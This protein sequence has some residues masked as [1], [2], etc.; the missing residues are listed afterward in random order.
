MLLRILRRPR[1]PPA[2]RSLAE[3]TRPRDRSGRRCGPGLKP[4]RPTLGATFQRLRG[5]RRTVRRRR[6]RAH[7]THLGLCG[8]RHLGLYGRRPPRRRRGEESGVFRFKIFGR[9]RLSDASDIGGKM[10]ASAKAA[11]ATADQGSRAAV[12]RCSRARCGVFGGGRFCAVE[13]SPSPQHATAARCLE[14]VPERS[15]AHVVAPTQTERAA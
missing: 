2:D 8:R 3:E 6:A 4:E 11:Q 15:L 14:E 9:V 10:G 5:R 13:A 7:R 1:A 12:P